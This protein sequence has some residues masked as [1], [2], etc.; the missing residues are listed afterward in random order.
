M[1]R[2]DNSH[3]HG[4]KPRQTTLSRI[5]IRFSSSLDRIQLDIQDLRNPW[6]LRLP[7][8]FSYST[9]ISKYDMPN[10]LAGKDYGLMMFS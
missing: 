8:S 3:Y 7:V 5:N 4:I 6:V 9:I 10:C 1:P 2:L